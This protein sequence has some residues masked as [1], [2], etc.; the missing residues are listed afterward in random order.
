MGT[1]FNANYKG[2]CTVYACCVRIVIIIIVSATMEVL[3]LPRVI[4]HIPKYLEDKVRSANVDIYST[5]E[6][7]L[8]AWL[9]HHYENQYRSVLRGRGAL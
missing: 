7:V 3:V 4:R 9:N 6:K 5:P 2:I 1:P 8:L